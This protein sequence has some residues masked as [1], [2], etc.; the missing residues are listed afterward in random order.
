MPTASDRLRKQAKKV[1]KEIHRMNGAVKDA[2]ENKLRKVRKNGS[3]HYEEG[4]SKMHQLERQ[5]V[6]TI[7][8]RPIRSTLIAAGV[9]VVFGGFWFRR[10]TMGRARTI[11]AE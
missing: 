1:T 2:A 7:R 6:Q 8:E 10:L 5:V 4:R 9:G 11:N 3:K